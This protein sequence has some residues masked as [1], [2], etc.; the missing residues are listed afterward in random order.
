MHPLEV[1]LQLQL[2]SDQ[3]A[4][5]SLPSVVFSITPAHFESSPHLQK[6]ISRVTSLIHSKHP[7]ARWAGLCLALQTSM[8]SKDLMVESA[9]N[10]ITIALPMLSVSPAR[11]CS[12]SL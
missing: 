4:V 10:W 12:L 2:G 9:Q 1:I 8:L 5:L 11:D 7:G 6:W 3:A